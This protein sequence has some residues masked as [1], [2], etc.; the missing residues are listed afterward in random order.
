MI[1]L[2]LYTARVGNVGS[3]FVAAVDP[4]Q[5]RAL[6]EQW[7]TERG[8]APSLVVKVQRFSDGRVVFAPG[9]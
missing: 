9:V 6:A 4:A 2:N 1:A 3:F 8:I 5:A 7:K